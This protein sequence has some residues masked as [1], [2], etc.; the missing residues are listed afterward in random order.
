MRITGGIYRGR[1][2]KSP[3]LEKTHPMGDREKLALFNSISPYLPGAKVLDL[4]AGTGALG[5]E[6]L[7]RGASEAFF[8]E[9]SGKAVSTLKA[10]IGLLMA[11]DGQ[12]AHVY[13]QKVAVF[14]QDALKSPN[15]PLFEVI[16]LDPPYDGFNPTEFTGVEKLLN[17]GGIIVLSHP[18]SVNPAEIFP[19]LELLSSRKYA[20]ANLSIFTK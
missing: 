12:N 15:L 13:H 11:S 10:N 2:L 4:F 9:G 1:E 17:R 7:S 19:E 8:V 14:L 18:A 3:L 6:A 5:L 16:L 20:A